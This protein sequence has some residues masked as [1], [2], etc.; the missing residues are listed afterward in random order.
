MTPVVKM[1]GGI[2]LYSLEQFNV[3]EITFCKY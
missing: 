1:N 2:A 3:M